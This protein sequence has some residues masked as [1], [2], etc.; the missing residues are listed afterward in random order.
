M[1]K[2][3]GISKDDPGREEYGKR[4][5]H[6]QVIIKITDTDLGYHFAAEAN[7]KEKYGFTFTI[8]QRCFLPHN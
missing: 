5:R 3:I 7:Y 8:S 2:K 4:K 1:V 6:E